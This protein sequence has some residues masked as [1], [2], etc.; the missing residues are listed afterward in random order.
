MRE[1]PQYKITKFITHCSCDRI[2][3]N[4]RLCRR[5]TNRKSSAPGRH[6][7]VGHG[8]TRGYPDQWNL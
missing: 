3:L 4:P 2:C 1:K 8:R 7:H 6:P 5:S